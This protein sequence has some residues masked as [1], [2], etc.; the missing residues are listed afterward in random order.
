MIKIKIYKSGI[1]R[2]SWKWKAISSNGRIIASG[3]GF[4]SV[5]L[6]K[7]SVNLLIDAFASKDYIMVIQ[8]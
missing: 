6:A 2:K 8:K 7:E 5:Q 1:I 4:N 3:R